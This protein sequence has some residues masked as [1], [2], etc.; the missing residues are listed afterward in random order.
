[1]LGLVP[2]RSLINKQSICQRSRTRPAKAFQAKASA[3]NA[4]A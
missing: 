3:L 4:C 1:M 2:V